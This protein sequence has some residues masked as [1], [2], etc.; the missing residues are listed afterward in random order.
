M[1]VQKGT[2]QKPHARAWKHPPEEQKLAG[3]VHTGKQEEREERE[4]HTE[5]ERER[6][7]RYGLMDGLAIHGGYKCVQVEVGTEQK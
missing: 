5:R 1:R 6:K 2:E 3:S 7:R 4:R